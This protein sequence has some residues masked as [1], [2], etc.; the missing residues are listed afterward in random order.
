MPP[1]TVGQ[2][3]GPVGVEFPYSAPGP[4]WGLLSLRPPGVSP[5]VNS[6]LRPCNQSVVLMSHLKLTASSSLD[7]G[8]ASCTTSLARFA[9]LGDLNGA[10]EQIEYDERWWQRRFL[11]ILLD[12]TVAKAFPRIDAL[13]FH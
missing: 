12:E 6:W 11:L 2:C 10:P 1:V 5:L 13:L 8:V 7:A 9:E 4:R 3:H